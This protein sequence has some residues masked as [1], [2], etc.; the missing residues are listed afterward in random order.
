MALGLSSSSATYYLGGL[1]QVTLC[2]W[3]PVSFICKVR[4]II[5][6]GVIALMWGFRELV[7]GTHTACVRSL[8]A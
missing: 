1:E 4:I 8:A 5:A 7:P 3:A 2:L 6:Q